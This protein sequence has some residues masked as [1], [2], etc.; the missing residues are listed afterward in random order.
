MIPCTWLWRNVELFENVDGFLL[1]IPIE[2]STGPL[3]TCLG[4]PVCCASSLLTSVW[5]AHASEFDTI[6]GRDGVMLSV[7]IGWFSIIF[8]LTGLMG[9]C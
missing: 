5:T 1:I 8:L 7:F 3:L 2:L 9:L 4:I 6:H